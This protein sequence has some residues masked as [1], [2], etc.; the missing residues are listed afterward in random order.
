MEQV[1]ER[2]YYSISE[3]CKLAKVKSHVLRYWES[4]F[5]I[6]NPPKNPAGNRTY[7]IED[8]RLILIIKHLL[9]EERYTIEGAKRK[10]E[11]YAE[12]GEN[13]MSILKVNSKSPQATSMELKQ[14]L[15]SLKEDLNDLIS[16]LDD[17]F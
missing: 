14:L 6:L 9:Y 5:P 15:L 17:N 1:G 10:L 11:Q 7:R 4:E 12:Q 16:L 3:V 13:Q 2:Y 8:I